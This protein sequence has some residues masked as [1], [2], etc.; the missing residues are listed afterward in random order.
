MKQRPASTKGLCQKHSTA[1]AQRL[2]P[3][4]CGSN[5]SARVDNASPIAKKS[6]G[7]AKPSLAK[8]QAAIDRCCASHCPHIK[9]HSTCLTFAGSHNKVVG[10]HL[11]SK[12][13]SPQVKWSRR[14][15]SLS[16]I[17]SNPIKT[18][19]VYYARLR[20]RAKLIID[21]TRPAWNSSSCKRPSFAKPQ[22]TFA[23]S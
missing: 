15:F 4:P 23:M 11:T 3:T 10:E 14:G 9:S 5:C 21:R 2:F 22:T 7:E 18:Y 17:L 1:K 6:F 8:D 20:F 16:Q 12:T 19:K 13:L